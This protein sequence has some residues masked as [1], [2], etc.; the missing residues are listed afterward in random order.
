[1][2]FGN[3]ER[4]DDVSVLSLAET[5]RASLVFSAGL[6]SAGKSC[7]GYGVFYGFL[8]YQ[9]RRCTD[10]LWHPFLPIWCI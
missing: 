3:H 8:M 9:Q 2:C 10:L 4:S 5:N 6:R 7:S 1:M